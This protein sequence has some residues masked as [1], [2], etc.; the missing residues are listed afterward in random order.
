MSSIELFEANNRFHEIVA[1]WSDNRFIVQSVKRVNQL[2]R[3][4]EYRQASRRVLRQ[5][6]AKEHLQNLDAIA[7]QDFVTAAARM[8]GHLDGARR[9]KVHDKNVFE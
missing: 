5:T 6:Q 8:R 3:L 7:Q 1:G 2:R 4:V 9:A